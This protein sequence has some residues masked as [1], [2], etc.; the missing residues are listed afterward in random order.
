M[1]NLEHLEI[2]QHSVGAWNWWRDKNPE[3]APELSEARLAGLDLTG[4]N[5]SNVT[6]IRADLNHANL[7]KANLTEADVTNANL[8]RADLCESNL[9]GAN[10][11]EANLR[12]AKFFSSI[13]FRAALNGA[14]LNGA[15]LGDANLCE[16][17]LCSAHLTG[18]IL[19]GVNLRDANLSKATFHNADLSGAALCGANLF[20]ADF[21]EAK[22]IKA[23]L[24]A[25]D[26][27]RTI[28][29]GVNFSSADLRDSDLS[30]SEMVGVNLSDA[31][32]YGAKLSG[33]NLSR[34]NLTEA[35][36]DGADFNKTKLGETILSGN[37]LSM[38]KGLETV[39]HYG[40]SYIS[41]DTLY[42][43]KGRVPEIF[44]RGCGLPES[45]I[46]QISSLI[47]AIEPIQFYSCFISYSS[48][49]QEFAERLHVDLQAKGVR[50]WFAPHDLPIGARIRTAIDESIRLH[51]K[52]L[53][54]L[55]ETS[56]SSQ[57]VE[58]EVETALSR[59]REQ[60]GRTVLFPIRID[61]GVM[62]SKAGWP[63]LLKNT[64]NVG[65]FTRWKEHDSYTKAFERLLR[66][67]KA[68]A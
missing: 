24:I 66:D 9:A 67:L 32:L 25:T 55:S 14:E 57:W 61:D 19:N 51:D 29:T 16:A 58:Q 35:R 38:V 53:L 64:R 10:F 2:L 12:G 56:V 13:M 17:D 68:G 23:N 3:I 7:F 11:C 18:A 20:R 1:A 31:N 44:L 33:A 50:C 63:A 45:L 54:V 43:S 6:L 52:L 42:K 41:T 62:E 39:L 48:A 59:E 47:E 60:K 30:D 5:F 4:V 46:V 65:D 22:L 49:D 21:S 40:P 36:I 34:A 26:F 37:D 15:R 28:L 27:R 8:S